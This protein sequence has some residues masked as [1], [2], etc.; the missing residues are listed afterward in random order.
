MAWWNKRRKEASDRH[1]EFIYLDEVSVISLLAGLQGEIKESVTN[2]LA[3]ADE[4]SVSASIATPGNAASLGSKFGS[5]RTTTNEVV[6][7]AVIQSTFR[8]LWQ[9][10]IGVLLHDTTGMKE[11]VRKPIADLADF[12][13]SMPRLKKSKLVVAVNDI[14]RGDLVEMD[15]AIEADQFFKMVTIGSTFL[16]LMEGRETLFGVSANEL[17]QVAPMIEVLKEL[18]VGLVPVRGLS[19][20]HRVI[21]LKG[22]SF[23]IAKELL[24]P[25]LLS[26]SRSLE[27]VGFAEAE[28]FWRDLRRTLFSGATYTAYARV[29]RS[30]L[31]TPWTPIK[32][33]DLLESISPGLRDEVAAPFERLSAGLRSDDEDYEVD[34]LARFQLEGFAN[35]LRAALDTQVNGADV[36]SA[37]VASGRDVIEA[38]TLEDRRRAF[39][40]VAIAI[41]GNDIDRDTLLTV[42][43]NWMTRTPDGVDSMTDE[44]PGTVLSSPPVQV[45]VGF[46]ALYW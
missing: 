1:R 4:S 13:R 40:G 7:R 22:E 6:R 42:R 18:S 9:R 33:A 37:I 23:V 32:I 31:E 8:D 21:D 12:E 11:K 38:A 25:G 30:V 39:E 15:L 43:S 10:D 24:T 14:R 19:T 45:E 34:E 29:E 28:S 26:E 5:T 46:V 17:R 44:S 35:E 20:S 41:G 3:R 2:T 27:L 36:E 16:D